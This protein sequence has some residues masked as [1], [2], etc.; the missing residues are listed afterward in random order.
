M[1]TLHFA[2]WTEAVALIAF[3]VSFSVFLFIL[4]AVFHVPASRLRRL[5]AFPLENETITSRQKHEP[6][7]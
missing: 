6:K 2:N 7:R 5:E 4:V 1:E 3:V